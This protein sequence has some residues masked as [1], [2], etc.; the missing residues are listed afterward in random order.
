VSTGGRVARFL[1]AASIVAGLWLA[2]GM[3]P[4]ACVIDL[5]QTHLAAVLWTEG[6]PESVYQGG[7]FALADDRDAR[8]AEGM[9]GLGIHPDDNG[10]FAY[11]PTYLALVRP[12]ALLPLPTLAAGVFFANALAVVALAR[13]STRLAGVRSPWIEDAAAVVGGAL[14]PACYAAVLGQNAILAVAAAAIAVSRVV[15]RGRAGPVEVALLVVAAIAK[16]WGAFFFG[17]LLLLRHHRAL[18]AAVAAYV[19]L[20]VVFPALFLPAALVE[21]AAEV[22]RSLFTQSIVSWNSHSIRALVHRLSWPDWGTWLHRWRP[23]HVP[24]WILAVEAVVM[25]AIAAAILWAVVRRRATTDA[26]TGAI[27]LAAAILPLG[28]CWTHTFVATYPLAALAATQRGLPRIAGV[29]HL[30]A[31]AFTQLTLNVWPSPALIATAPATWALVYSLPTLTLLVCL[32]A[33]LSDALSRAPA[34][35]AS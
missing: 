11:S 14:G 27:V 9:A 31:L 5:Y 15:E 18:A 1:G 3:R 4:T 2:M 13:A 28:V 25:L 10:M 19:V 22:R 12:V 16:P 32:G 33:V 7:V 34:P 24:A 8:W 23:L 30:L 35:R 29:A 20:D 17:A 21:G 26:E 6:H